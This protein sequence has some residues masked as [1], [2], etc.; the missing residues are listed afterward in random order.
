MI[1]RSP[2]LVSPTGLSVLVLL[3]AGAPAFAQ[4]Q[5]TT[6]D[7]LRRELSR[8]DVISIIETTGKGVKG[9]VVR[10]GDSDIG[11]RVKTLDITV[12]LAAIRSLERGRDPVSNG[13]IRGASIGAGITLSMFVWALAVDANEAD[14]WAPI[15][16]G[17]G[18]LFTGIGALTGWAIDA[19]QSKPALRF[20]SPPTLTASNRIAPLRSRR[21]GMHVRV[22]FQVP[23]GRR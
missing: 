18:A 4:V 10:V 13:A 7:E 9:R 6:L 5:L 22:S 16:L 20:D 17:M 11:V 21:R 2:V 14:E 19:A 23:A 15:Y 3:L 8:G 12:P 1:S